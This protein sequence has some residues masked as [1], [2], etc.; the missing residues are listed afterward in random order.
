MVNQ[1]PLFQDVDEQYAPLFQQLCEQARK[2]MGLGNLPAALALLQQGIQ[3]AGEH[4]IPLSAKGELLLEYGIVQCRS[5]AYMGH[6]ADEALATFAFVQQ[7]ATDLADQRLEAT[8]L[9]WIGQAQ[10]YRALNAFKDQ[11]DFVTPLHYFQQA[12]AQR[13]RIGDQPGCCD[14]SLHIGCVYQSQD[15]KEQAAPYFEQAL[16][17]AEQRDYKPQMAEALLHLGGIMQAKGDMKT[18]YYALSK[19][20]A[21]REELNLRLE[22]PSTYLCMGDILHACRDFA[23]AEQFYNRAAQLAHELALPIPLIFALLS[24]GYLYLAQAQPG[25]AQEEFDK[26]CTLALQHHLLFAL[27]ASLAAKAQAI[28]QLS[29]A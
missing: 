6:N 10:Y 8:A 20:L 28:E 21:L 11:A 5:I 1:S 25:R 16:S 27:S 17:L 29:Q 7:V 14:T 9:D 12:F 3:L 22:L 13:R 18:A 19:C 24:S 23:Q 26:A 2:H 4:E 15:Q